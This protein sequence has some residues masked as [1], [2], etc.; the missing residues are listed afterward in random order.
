MKSLKQVW[1]A[2]HR[3]LAAKRNMN[4]RQGAKRRLTLEKQLGFENHKT[5][6]D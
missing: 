2:A 3:P 4:G 5:F 6:F 1:A